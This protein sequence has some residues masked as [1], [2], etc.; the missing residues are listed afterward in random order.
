VAN[1]RLAG[2]QQKIGS[3]SSS[4]KMTPDWGRLYTPANTPAKQRLKAQ[5]ALYKA[6]G[7]RMQRSGISLNLLIEIRAPQSSRNSEKDSKN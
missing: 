4:S 1:T 6:I 2:P 5:R 3:M 7:K